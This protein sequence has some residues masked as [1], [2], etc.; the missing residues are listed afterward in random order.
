VGQGLTL[1]PVLSAQ[2]LASAF[3]AGGPMPLAQEILL[4]ETRLAG[5]WFEN[6]RQLV[7][8]LADGERV[9][10]LRQPD[11]PHDALAIGVHAPGG[12]LLGFVPRRDNPI[13]ARLMDAG[14]LLFARLR[15]GP[16]DKPDWTIELVMREL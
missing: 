14:K 11:N 12:A 4:L 2:L 13:P 5:V 6:R 8:P 1:S 10:L 15:R 3:G 9:T 7:E 16:P